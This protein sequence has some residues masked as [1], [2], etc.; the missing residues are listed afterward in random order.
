MNNKIWSFKSIEDFIFWKVVPKTTKINTS[1]I[2]IN[3]K[4]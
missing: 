2:E 4:F 1:K 3:N